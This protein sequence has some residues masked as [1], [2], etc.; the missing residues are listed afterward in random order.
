MQRR[1][2]AMMRE[3]I[4]GL[5]RKTSRDDAKAVQAQSFGWHRQFAEIADRWPRHG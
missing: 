5:D 4:A 2:L 3:A 1:R